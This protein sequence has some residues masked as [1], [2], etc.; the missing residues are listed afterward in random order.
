MPNHSNISVLL[1]FKVAEWSKVELS[2]ALEWWK[3]SAAHLKCVTV[4][5]STTLN[6]SLTL[7]FILLKVLL[8]FYWTRL[9]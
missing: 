1:E 2:M 9:F 3:K 6:D 8:G 5:S 7:M 4:H